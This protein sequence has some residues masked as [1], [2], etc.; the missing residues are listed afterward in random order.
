[1][2]RNYKVKATGHNLPTQKKHDPCNVEYA[3]RGTGLELI[4]S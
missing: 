3:A 1:V 4:S 2:D